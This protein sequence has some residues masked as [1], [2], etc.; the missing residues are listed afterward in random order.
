MGSLHPSHSPLV[1]TRVS[2]SNPRPSAGGPPLPRTYPF[3]HS[4]FTQSHHHLLH[5]PLLRTYPFPRSAFTW[6]HR[7][8]LHPPLLR[9]Y[10]FPR[11]AFMRPHRPLLHPPHLRT[12]PFPR[13]VFT[14]PH[15]QHSLLLNWEN[16][17][18]I[19]SKITNK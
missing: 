2:D 16:I 19:R 1:H 4:A 7:H 12:Y 8:L 6:P 11:S 14:W 3:P 13:S 15:H 10:L 5:P 18:S 17:P 9:T